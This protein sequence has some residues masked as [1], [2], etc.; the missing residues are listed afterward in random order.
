MPLKNPYKLIEKANKSFNLYLDNHDEIE[1]Y[2]KYSIREKEEIKKSFDSFL[3]DYN[4][5]QNKLNNIFIQFCDLF[6]KLIESDSVNKDLINNLELKI[7]DSIE[8]NNSN[9]NDIV[10]HIDGFN[11]DIMVNLNQIED[12]FLNNNDLIKDNHERQLATISALN[13]SIRD[14]F[15]SNRELINDNVGAL[16][17][18]IRD[19]F[20]SNRELINDNVG[21][22][23]KSIRDNFDS[24]RELINDNVGALNKSIRDNFD[25]NRELINDNVGALNK[26]I[27]EN[28]DKNRAV[29]I[30]ES[31]NQLDAIQDLKEIQIDFNKTYFQKQNIIRNLMDSQ[32]DVNAD[33]NNAIKLFTQNYHECKNYFFNDYERELRQYLNTDDLFRLCY[34][35]NIKF[36]SYSP[37]E[38]K[39]LLKTKEGIIL[40]TNNRFYTIKEVIG[41]DGYSVPQLYMFDDFVVFDVGMNRAYAS[42]RFAQFE[43]CS[44]VYGFEIDDETYNK[45]VFNININPKLSKKIIPYN[46]G[47]SNQNKEL[48]LYY[49]EGADGLNTI[50]NDFIDI[51]YELKENKGKIKSKYVDVKKSSEIIGDIIENNNIKS[52]LVLKIDVEGSE[53]DILD[54]LIDSGLINKFDLI[55][56]EGHN[57]ND[58]DVSEDLLNL[59]FKEIEKKDNVIVYNFAYVKEDYYDIWPL[60]N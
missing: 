29:I 18:S 2:I 8:T 56:G 54:D 30:N 26:S 12:T 28:F 9:H 38:N 36:L 22:L 19:N 15:D 43:N 47:L 7:I 48:E 37:S 21:A 31:K 11:N 17:K 39:I 20:D 34:F 52:N 5:N 16:N 32:I 59:G 57:F 24:N 60:R 3:D 1:Q 50:Q 25:S 58:R 49:L 4:S 46:F 14:N 45:A 51:Q 33:L 10:D 41:F 42:L 55:L 13:K 23:N 35:N 27:E 40:G 44:A 53:F 6:Q